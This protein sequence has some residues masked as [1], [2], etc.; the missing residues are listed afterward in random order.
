MHLERQKH[1]IITI[2]IYIIL[3]SF[4]I[5]FATQGVRLHTEEEV[6]LGFNSETIYS[7]II[8]TLKVLIIQKLRPTAKN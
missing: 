3:Y 4:T 5:Y 2:N 8:I 7:M 1:V 6:W